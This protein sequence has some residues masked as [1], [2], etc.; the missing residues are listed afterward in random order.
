MN[1]ILKVVDWNLISL[2][3]GGSEVVAKVEFD[4]NYFWTL[5]IPDLQMLAFREGN[6]LIFRGFNYVPQS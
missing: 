5:F 2:E 3:N 6:N 1:P 4:G